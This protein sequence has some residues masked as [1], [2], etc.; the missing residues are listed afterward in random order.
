MKKALLEVEVGIK[1]AI[2]RTHFI[3]LVEDTLEE[4][5]CIVV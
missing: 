4:K 2:S 1:K 5:V 3:M